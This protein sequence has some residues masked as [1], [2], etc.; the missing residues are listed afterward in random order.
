MFPTENTEKHKNHREDEMSIP[1]TP[2]LLLCGSYVP[3]F[4]LFL[5][6]KFLFV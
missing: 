5:K 4:P 6:V 3:L 2:L 1:E